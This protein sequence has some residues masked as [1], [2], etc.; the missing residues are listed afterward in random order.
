MSQDSKLFFDEYGRCIPN[1]LKAEVHQE[2]R[3]YFKYI[4]PEINYKEIYQRLNEYLKVSNQI[5]LEEFKSRAEGILSKISDDDRCKNIVNGV[6]VPFILPKQQCNDIG[7]AMEGVYLDAVKA[8]FESFFPK[9]SFV[10]HCN[11]SLEGKLSV[12]NGSRHEKLIY[13]MGQGVVVGYFFPCLLEYSVPA[14]LEKIE[15]LPSQ[16]LLAGGFDSAAA[17][18][19]SPEL[20]LRRDGYPP[21]L[22][23][24]GVSGGIREDAYHFEAYGYD[25]TFNNRPHF[26]KVA[27]Y[28]SSGL[29][30]LG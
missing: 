18:V 1:K 4:Q 27:E 6:G 15:E 23:L 19:G 16:F 30:V 11:S 14:A 13:E 28:W 22:W 21:L 3:R 26:D 25:L 5:S 2:S 8:S 24:S 29:V 9:Y 12:V 10:N 7:L 17:L 20:L